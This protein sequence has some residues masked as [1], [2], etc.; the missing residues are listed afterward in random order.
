MLYVYNFF[1]GNINQFITFDIIT[2]YIAHHITE[3]LNIHSFATPYIIWMVD[4]ISCSV[5]NVKFTNNSSP[6]ITV[7]SNHLLQRTTRP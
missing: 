4:Q 5:N 2:L 6:T 1:P 7:Y 3:Q